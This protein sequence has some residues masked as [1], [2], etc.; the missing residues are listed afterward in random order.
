MPFDPS[1]PFEAVAE[2]PAF[3]SSKPFEASDATKPAFDPSQSFASA[4]DVDESPSQAQPEITVGAQI[5]QAPQL[6]AETLDEA[7]A[8]TAA[9]LN[10]LRARLTREGIRRPDVP[11]AGDI[12]NY[13]AQAGEQ[14]ESFFP[15]ESGHTL[16]AFAKADE[17]RAKGAEDE[18]R[19]FTQAAQNLPKEYGL[20]PNLNHGLVTQVVRGLTK[21]AAMAAM[22]E[23]GGIPLL[24]LQGATEAYGS[25]KGAGGDDKAA[26]DRATKS[27]IGLIIFGASNKAVA[28][29]IAK[30]LGDAGKLQT[31]LT[32]SLGQSAGN[33]V[34][35]R[36]MAAYDA[37]SEAP[38]NERI[39]AALAA[40]KDTNAESLAQNI[41]FGI[42]GGAGATK[43]AI[44]KAREE[45]PAAPLAEVEGE[46]QA[47]A[48]REHAPTPPAPTPFAGPTAQARLEVAGETANVVPQSIVVGSGPDAVSVVVP[49]PPVEE[50]KKGK[51]TQALSD[52]QKVADPEQ[53]EA[54]MQEAIRLRD[55]ALK[56]SEPPAPEP[57]APAST[58]PFDLFPLEEP[59][60]NEIQSTPEKVQAPEEQPTPEP[61]SP[62]SAQADL[63][64]LLGLVSKSTSPKASTEGTPTSAQEAR[65][66]AKAP[67][68]SSDE[69]KPLN[70][71]EKARLSSLSDIIQ[72]VEADRKFAED[73][74]DIGQAQSLSK[75][76]SKYQKELD[77]LKERD[78]QTQSEEPKTTGIRNAI[79]DDIAKAMGL[80]ERGTPA[81]YEAEAQLADAQKS[82][83]ENSK[84][85]E[86]IVRELQETPRALST[87]ENNVM[88]FE[89]AARQTE[90]NAALKA[91]KAN[92]SPAAKERLD[93]ARTAVADAIEATRST[94]TLQGQALES[95]KRIVNQ[96]YELPVMQAEAQIAKGRPL[97][98][99]ESTDI[100]ALHDKI[101]DLQDQLEKQQAKTTEKEA[102][103]TLANLIREEVRNAKSAK[104]E[105]RSFMDVLKEGHDKALENI[106]KRT[107]KGIGKTSANPIEIL[108]P[109]VFVDVARIGA[110]KIAKGIANLA[111]FT[112]AMVADIGEWIRPSIDDIFAQSQKLHTKANEAYTQANAKP[113]A[114]EQARADAAEGKGPSHKTIF[115]M[116]REK[117]NAGGKGLEVMDQ[118]RAD[119]EPLYPGIT[120]EQVL[121]AFSE[122]GKVRYPSKE[123]DLT[124][125]RRI[126]RLSQL[127]SAIEDAKRGQ[128]P[129]KSGAQRDKADQEIRDKTKELDRL[130][131]EAGIETSSPEQQL[132]STN[133][134]RK[135]ALENQILDLDRLLQTG[136]KA[137]A[138]KAVPDSAEVERLRSIRDAMK[139]A[140]KDIED[141]SK[142]QKS[143][144]EKA[145][146]SRIKAA[147]K[148]VA[149]LNRR[150]TEGDI[151]PKA[152]K[153]GPT[154]DALEKLQ[155]IRDSMQ[156]QIREMRRS[157]RPETSPEQQA[158]ND[159]LASRERW[160]QILNGEATITKPKTK[161]ALTQIEEDVKLEIEGMKQLVKELRQAAKT[162]DPAAA[163]EK[164]QIKAIEKSIAEYERRVR[165]MD[166][167][168][169]G[170]Q[171]GPPRSEEM[172]KAKRA[173]E[174][175]KAMY[176]A[177]KK[178]RRPP[179][180]KDARR[181]ALA[182]VTIKRRM[183]KLGDRIKNSDY[184]KPVKVDLVADKEL[185]NLRFEEAKLKEKFQRDLFEDRL[186]NRTW[187]KKALDGAV[188][189]LSLSRALKT[190]FDVSAP[191][192]QGKF[193]AAA[194]PI[195]SARALGDMFRSFAS[196]KQAFRA[197]EQLEARDNFRNGNY[198]AAKLALTDPNSTSMTKIE[199]DFQSRWANK[200]P[201]VAG[202]GRAYSTYLNKIRADVFDTMLDS[203]FPDGATT[204]EMKQLGDFVNQASGRG[205]LGQKGE[206]AGPLLNNIFFSP[207]FI[208][209]RLQLAVGK[210]LWTRNPRI[211]KAVAAEYGRYIVGMSAYMGLLALMFGDDKETNLKG[212]DKKVLGIGLDPRKK[213]TFMTIRDGDTRYDVLAGLKQII[214]TATQVA[215]GEKVKDSG[216]VLDLVN[217]RFGGESVGDV[218]DRFLRSKLS[219]GAALVADLTTRHDFL[220]RDNKLFPD[221]FGDAIS[222]EGGI[223]ANSV[224][225]MTVPQIRDALREKGLLK[226]LVP[227]ILTE[228]GEGVNTYGD[229]DLK[230][231]RQQRA[232]N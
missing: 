184:S 16:E 51:I 23:A 90:F 48:A 220:G 171:Q 203:W 132:A 41:G 137:A 15:P 42:M 206:M 147:E 57:L 159:A 64:R 125:L 10:Y 198:K 202:S 108:D 105:G 100:E 224:L 130:M 180:D 200:I 163:K 49:G 76:Q 199:E 75:I 195:I 127:Q 178:A 45:R 37:A 26:T 40:L 58:K 5:R 158:L 221:S 38:E 140:A 62:L 151:A 192:R 189:A 218:T 101:K 114:I 141:A 113:L 66:Q 124:E 98:E 8:Q 84:L 210:S 27:L 24:A 172:A 152:P 173:Q 161:E 187:E 166:F 118:V 223:L 54:F 227:L 154:S 44:S 2:K 61:Q 9:G 185:L 115:D 211:R 122:Y 19:F 138:S 190:S 97:T 73:E 46:N 89:M 150:L 85:G 80:P 142:P 22:A 67:E 32:Q 207:K 225:P 212:E 146:E 148:S 183:E 92:K 193:I 126:R 87:T 123:A 205:S 60:P 117:V 78:T 156:E 36:A 71:K 86:N 209:S 55:E 116:A 213:G 181:L 143:P 162:R 121:N 77:T 29:G 139:Q 63:E 109:T 111:D 106:A 7:G 119:L 135:T 136:E 59:K 6:V 69:L 129:K 201:G 33:E 104:K 82:I 145:L 30:Y 177:A 47:R 102:T 112:K 1:Q 17:A 208:A 53:R 120:T 228:R 83:E 155:S 65:P 186:R 25:V 167:A 174:A 35:A 12:R 133:A 165:E 179:V 11:E 79:T 14:S 107:Q 194:H 88:A 103:R 50:K 34:T 13:I 131:R 96:T 222:G 182:K 215:T 197:Q 18:A 31:F 74:G 188:Q 226:G 99:K 3:D 153:S 128:S 4:D 164:A 168:G 191:L 149:E 232:N 39:E 28:S 217:P 43:S 110:Y 72:N 169:K 219:P 231:Y 20:D 175:A 21:G 157:S 216:E 81:R 230:E 160:Q 94:G 134:A 214:S 91:A 56:V 176:E 68:P 196:E 70:E 204:Q 229:D 144:D 52:R 93:A 95:R 170:K